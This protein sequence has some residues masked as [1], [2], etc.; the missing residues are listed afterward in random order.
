MQVEVFKM[1]TY[2]PLWETMRYKGISQYKLI[3]EFNFSAGQLSRLR[4]NAYVSTHTIET[5]CKILDCDVSDIMCYEK[6]SV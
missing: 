3:K 5:L 4:K 1:I 2:T 6:D